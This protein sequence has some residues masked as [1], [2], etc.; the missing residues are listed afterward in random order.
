M[1]TLNELIDRAEYWIGSGFD[2]R[3]DEKLVINEAGRFLFSMHGWQWAV[4]PSVS[5]DL[6][7]GQNYA[8]LPSDFRHLISASSSSS[9][10]TPVYQTTP[11]TI[12]LLRNG[13]NTS[14]LFAWWVAVERP[15]QQ[16]ETSPRPSPRLAVY[17]TPSSD[18][19]GGLI[20]NAR[21][22]WTELSYGQQVANVPVEMDSLLVELVT[23]HA[24]HYAARE[25]MSVLM[26]PLLRSD[27]LRSLKVDDGRQQNATGESTG[28]ILQ[29]GRDSSD[30]NAFLSN[31]PVPLT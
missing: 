12:D 19:T 30:Y 9:W 31:T 11:G 6:V 21:S 16:D 28:G 22:G 7:S 5:I 1:L 26:E 8:D 29:D 15:T 25:P 14:A 10:T 24:K 18:T 17:P 23:I 3:L 2:P 13:N 4:Q 27:M 20:L